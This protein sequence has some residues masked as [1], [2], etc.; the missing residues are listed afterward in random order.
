MNYQKKIL[1]YLFIFLTISSYFIGFYIN[2]NSAGAG[3]Y[4][5][6]LGHVW[7]NLN[8]YLENNTLESIDD[9][10]YYSNRT[11]LIYILHKYLNP[12]TENIYSFRIS[13]FFLS[14]ISPIL[15]YFCLARKYSN[16]KKIYLVLISVTLLLSPYFRTSSY[17]GLEENFG[18][19]STLIAFI[20]YLKYK[21]IKSN[22]NIFLLVFFSSLCVY[23]DQKLLIVPL[24]LFFNIIFSDDQL[25]NKVILIFTY[26]LFSLPYFYLI[27]RW[28]G[29]FPPSHKELHDFN[30]VLWDNIIYTISI[31]SIYFA[32]FLF[33]KKDKITHIKKVFF[34]KFFL[35]SLLALISLIFYVEIFYIRPEFGFHSNFDGGGAIRKLSFILFE[36][37]LVQK[38]FLLTSA[39]FGWAIIYSFID[40]KNIYIIL[41]YLILSPFIYPL[42]Q[43]T[44]DPI[45]IILILLCFFEEPQ[46]DLKNFIFVSVYFSIFL[47]SAIFYYK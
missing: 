38:I 46:I 11:P 28:Q 17:W 35:I 10:N 4:Q 15:F 12:L 25:K 36:S 31:M 29:I 43:E 14:I 1:T 18:I 34:D 23:F 2:E 42:Y 13:V 47:L 3:S 21:E 5:G 32:P 41:F 9:L 16:V 24:I 6:D 40:N 39:L 30:T 22:K 44:F 37:P 33:L 20:F 45:L 7:K 26:F 8:I 19:I 27:F